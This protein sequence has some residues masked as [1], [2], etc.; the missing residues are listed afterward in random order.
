MISTY[1]QLLEEAT[2]S[3][4]QLSQKSHVIGSLRLVVALAILASIYF[5]F[6]EKSWL[7]A[8]IILLLLIL[9]FY[10]VV[11]HKKT[12]LFRKIAQQKIAINE[13]EIAFL[14][15]NQF[16]SVNGEEF[17]D[18]THPYSYDLDIFGSHSLY[19]YI[20]RTHTFLGRKSLAAHFLSPKADEIPHLQA[21][22]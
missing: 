2:L 1:Q 4:K 8:A 16:F 14:E 21:V 20:N 15:K 13:N 11:I 5:A 22:T 18:D 19:Q 6:R 12:N 3:F 17:Q 10:L 7:I 9:F